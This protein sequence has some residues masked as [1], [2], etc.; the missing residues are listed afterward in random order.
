MHPRLKDLLTKYPQ[1]KTDGSV[2]EIW[3]G[4]KLLKGIPPD[5]LCPHFIRGGRHFY[6]NEISLLSSGE[7]VIPVRWVRVDDELVA[8]CWMLEEDMSDGCYNLRDETT[9]DLP[10]SLFMIDFPSLRE[11]ADCP[12]LNGED[13]REL[14]ACFADGPI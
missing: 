11:R 13:E 14:P 3:H 12:Q 1:R 2:S 4:D 10:S 5:Q 6:V 9:V 7:Y 8:E